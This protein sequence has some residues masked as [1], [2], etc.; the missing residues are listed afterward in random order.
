MGKTLAE[1]RKARFDYFIKDRFEAGLSL[2]G[3][4]VK[5][6]RAGNVSLDESFVFYD[7]LSGELW[8]KNSYF[9]PYMDGDVKTQKNKRNRKLLLHRSEIDKIAKAVVVKGS[10]CVITKMYIN[11]AGFVKMEIA[12]A[13]GKSTYDKKK[14]L[15]ERDIARETNKVLQ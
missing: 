3:W 10:A 1:N 7:K 8:L 2:E 9:A 14:A 4:E 12:I 15:K 5:S 6:A 13:T 11:K